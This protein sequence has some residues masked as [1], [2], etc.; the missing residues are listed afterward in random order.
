MN[1]T[2]LTGGELFLR[3]YRVVRLLCEG[4]MGQVFLGRH[5]QTGQEVVIKVTRDGL[6][7]GLRAAFKREME[8][9][10]RFRH[11]HAVSLLDGALEGPDRPCLI[12]E[13]VRGITLEE[14]LQ[15]HGRLPPERVGRLLGQLCQVLH[16][17][18]RMGILH[19]D[20]S[21]ENLMVVPDDTRT[22]GAPEHLKVMDFGLARLGHGFFVPMEKLT[23]SGNSI[24]GGTPDY[25]CP[26]QIRGEGVDHRGDLYSVGVILFKMLTGRLPFDTGDDMTDILLAHVRM[27]PSSF[28]R[29]GVDDVA[30]A[31]EAVVQSCLAKH[32]SERP[33]SA[34]DLAERFGKALGRPIA[35]PEDFPTTAVERKRQPDADGT[36]DRFE[37]WMPEQIAVMKLRAFIAGVG[38]EVVASEP[39][40]LR[41]RLRDPRTK[42]PEARG[43]LSFLGL[44][45]RT[46]TTPDTLLIELLM[47]KQQVD[48]RGLVEITV[49]L[50]RDPR[51]NG[52]ANMVEQTMRRGFGERVCRELRAYLMIG[53]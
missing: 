52:D 43:L 39:G 12:L 3:A 40:S 47:E 15:R 37:A 30:P 20:L 33:Q 2:K 4:G 1:A 45:R 31:V 53:R 51:A 41:V 26:E 46:L 44:G 14:L 16:A 11:A 9:M 36:L 48:G 8:V 49:V 50:P 32:P 28:E 23:G 22:G 29:V 18:H 21:A 35:R 17:A 19:R 24:G 7:E 34:R 10:K 27:E 5:V 42:P 13:Y 6:A 38:G 25:M